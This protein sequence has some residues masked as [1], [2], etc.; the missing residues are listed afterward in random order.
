MFWSIQSWL[1]SLEWKDARIPQMAWEY[2]RAPVVIG[3]RT[4]LTNQSFLETSE[5]VIVE[6]FR[7]EADHIEVRLVECL[8]APGTATVRLDLPHHSAMLT[9]LAGNKL[10]ALPKGERY[11]FPV[12]SQQYVNDSISRRLQRWQSRSQ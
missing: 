8:G 5:N 10:S 11:S 1:T 2:N 7:R 6:G 12:R 9:D 3:S 4:S